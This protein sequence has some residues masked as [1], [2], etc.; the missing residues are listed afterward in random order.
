MNGTGRSRTRGLALLDMNEWTC[1]KSL[2]NADHF[3]SRLLISAVSTPTLTEI[4][5]PPLTHFRDGGERDLGLGRFS[6]DV[7][8]FSCGE[9]TAAEAKHGHCD[10]WLKFSQG[11]F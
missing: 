5:G 8:R 3:S 4:Y 9:L 1:N 11:Y 6:P 10:R 2:R 7:R